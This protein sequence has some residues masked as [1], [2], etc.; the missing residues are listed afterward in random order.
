MVFE[1]LLLSLSSSAKYFSTDVFEA[2]PTAA[3]VNN[4]DDATSGSSNSFE[5]DDTEEDLDDRGLD[6]VDIADDPS[7][8]LEKTVPRD[9]GVFDDF[10][11]ILSNI[12]LL[13]EDGVFSVESDKISLAWLNRLA[14]TGRMLV[15]ISSDRSPPFAAP[16]LEVE[17]NRKLSLSATGI[18]NMSIELLPQDSNWPDKLIEICHT[19]F[20]HTSYQLFRCL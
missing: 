18:T 9:F 20:K 1:R 6:D 16:F 14:E 8:L 17:F 19:M 10:P 15:V 11:D 13:A 3:F 7:A 5:Y 12:A 2:D 4:V